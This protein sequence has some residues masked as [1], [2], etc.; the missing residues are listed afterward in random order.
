MSMIAPVRSKPPT[1]HVKQQLEEAHSA[2]DELHER[3]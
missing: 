2:S 1:H 3:I